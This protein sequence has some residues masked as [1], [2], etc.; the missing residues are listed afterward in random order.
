MEPEDL[1]CGEDTLPGSQMVISLLTHMAERT[2][3]LSEDSFIIVI[4]S[5]TRAPLSHSYQSNNIC[6]IQVTILKGKGFP[7]GSVVKNLPVVW[8]DPWIWKIPWI[9]KWQ[10]TPVFLPGKSHKQRSLVGYSPWDRKT[11]GHIL[12]SKTTATF[13]EKFGALITASKK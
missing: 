13:K 1:V 8:F 5:F 6:S 7:G 10:P 12:V 11:V 9:R 3:D 2:K 4:V